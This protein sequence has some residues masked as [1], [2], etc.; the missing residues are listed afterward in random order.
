MCITHRVI[1]TIAP[2]VFSI[3]GTYRFD[4]DRHCDE[5]QRRD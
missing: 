1:G 5:H 2:H 3:A 4:R